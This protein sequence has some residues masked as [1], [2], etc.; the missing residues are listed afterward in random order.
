M[1]R[2]GKSVPD[3]LLVSILVNAIKYVLQ[4]LSS[5]PFNIVFIFLHVLVSVLT[6]NVT[7]CVC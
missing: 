7:A 4:F 2:R 3:V 6:Y 1:L 5:Y